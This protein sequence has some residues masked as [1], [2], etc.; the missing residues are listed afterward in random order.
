MT[1]DAL[2]RIASMTKALTSIA[3]MQLVEAGRFASMIRWKNIFRPLPNCV[4]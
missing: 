4:F 2:F 3:A 1:A